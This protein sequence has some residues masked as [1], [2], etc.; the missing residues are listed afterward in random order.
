MGPV[1]PLGNDSAFAAPQAGPEAH[2]QRLGDAAA[3]RVTKGLTTG[4]HTHLW[5][6]A[7]GKASRRPRETQWKGQCQDAGPGARSPA[8]LWKVWSTQVTATG[9][10]GAHPSP[11]ATRGLQ[12]PPHLRR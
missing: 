4:K 12:H 2:T 3:P 10:C 6:S 5:V 1:T 8:G 7:W 11:S 9:G